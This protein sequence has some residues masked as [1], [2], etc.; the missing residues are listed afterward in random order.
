MT[1]QETERKRP[2][3]KP[4]EGPL[5]KTRN[6]RMDDQRWQYFTENL[7]AAWLRQQIDI[8]VACKVKH[9]SKE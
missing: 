1:Q 9:P 3:P 8:A 5:Q 7:G 4:S 6:V 2:G